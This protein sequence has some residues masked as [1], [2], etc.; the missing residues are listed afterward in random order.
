MISPPNP[1]RGW[2]VARNLVSIALLLSLTG[3]RGCP[4]SNPPIHLNPNMDLQP[5][6]RAQ[7]SSEFFADGASM[8]SPVAGTVARGAIPQADAFTTGQV[9]DG[10]IQGIP[11]AI[12]D[13]VLARG[14][15]RYAIY[16]EPCHAASANGKGMLFHR[17]QI[18]SANLLD[19]RLVAMPDG[20][21]F[22]TISQGLGLMPAYDYLIPVEDRW[23]IIAHVRTLQGGDAASLSVENVDS[24]L[25][26]QNS[27]DEAE[28]VVVDEGAA[29]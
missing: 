22:S 29:G 26:G 20:E 15:E 16:C 9:A 27:T 6:Y 17:T 4:K 21:M 14:E 23:A 18:E 25:D 5:K 12:D 24:S 10:Y 2:V 1:R 7:S 8:R 13:A 19:D 11:M 28:A 3:C